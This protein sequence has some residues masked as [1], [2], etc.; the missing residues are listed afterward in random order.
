ML[1]VYPGDPSFCR[2][3]HRIP[4]HLLLPTPI[5]CVW[6]Q[7]DERVPVS[8]RLVVSAATLV[9]GAAELDRMHAGVGRAD[10]QRKRL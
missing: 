7:P 1:A 4:T 5:A 10:T 2:G 8:S 9:P 3:P 6:N